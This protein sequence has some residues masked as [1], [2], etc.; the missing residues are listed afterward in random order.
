MLCVQHYSIIH[1][2]IHYSLLERNHLNGTAEAAP[3]A[4]RLIVFPVDLDTL[5]RFNC[6]TEKNGI[7]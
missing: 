5:S 3:T 1:C 4:E 6:C 2:S 7:A